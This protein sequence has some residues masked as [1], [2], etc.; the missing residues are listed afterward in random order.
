[1]DNSINN[2]PLHIPLSQLTD[3]K[4]YTFDQE[5]IDFKIHFVK[6]EPTV[7]RHSIYSLFSVE[8]LINNEPAGY[9]LLSYISED[10]KNKYFNNILEYYIYRHSDSESIEEAYQNNDLEN[11]CLLLNKKL[12]SGYQLFGFSEPLPYTTKTI[13]KHFNILKTYIEEKYTNHYADFI[14]YSYNRPTVEMMR[15]Y[16]EKDSKYKTFH[17]CPAEECPRNPNSFRSKGISQAL[18]AVGGLVTQFYG[19]NLYASATQTED[20]KKMWNILEQL[21][22]FKVLIDSFN[23]VNTTNRKQ[24]IIKE[25]KKLIVV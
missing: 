11:L 18:Y 21:P 16:N 22:H 2:I 5:L 9:I 13:Q 19:M 23:T 12:G 8:A 20:G 10:I 14:S 7:N 24:L 1:M 17:T 25:R 15:V 3:K 4:F 6:E